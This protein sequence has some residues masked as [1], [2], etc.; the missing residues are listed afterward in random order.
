ME[1]RGVLR[2]GG[3][4]RGG[5]T[6]DEKGKGV[7]RILDRGKVMAFRSQRSKEIRREETETLNETAKERDETDAK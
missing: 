6:A 3:F 2:C 5:S 4:G 1:Q 7:D